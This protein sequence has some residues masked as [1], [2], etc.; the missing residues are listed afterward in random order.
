M[1]PVIPPWGILSEVNLSFPGMLLPPP[2]TWTPAL[3]S[4]VASYSF[5]RNLNVGELPH[6]QSPT[7]AAG[8]KATVGCRLK[9]R[10]PELMGRGVVH[11]QG[12]DLVARHPCQ[13]SA[14]L[15]VSQTWCGSWPHWRSVTKEQQREECTQSKRAR[16][17]DE[18][19]TQGLSTGAQRWVW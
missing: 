18:Q 9:V 15:S 17:G 6:I 8:A 3:A 16:S 5:P 14:G 1:T 12:L 19:I 4:P 13:G 10:F 7:S 11:H 2:A